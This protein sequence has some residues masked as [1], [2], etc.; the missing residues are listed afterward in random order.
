MTRCT[1]F[2]W[3]GILLLGGCASSKKD[4]TFILKGKMN[5]LPAG[6]VVL[7]HMDPSDRTTHTMDSV[8]YQDGQFNWRGR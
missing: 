3:A 5:G 2:F 7:T 6:S 8:P 4:Y 1:G